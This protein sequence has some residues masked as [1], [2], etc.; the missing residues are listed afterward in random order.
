MRQS[1]RLASRSLPRC[2]RWR[3]GRP[4]RVVRLPVAAIPRARTLRQTAGIWKAIIDS[5][6]DEIL[7]AALLGPE[8]GEVITT[9]QVA[10]AAGL[11]YTVLRDAVITHPTMGEAC[12]PPV[13][14]LAAG[15]VRLA[16]RRSAERPFRGGPGVQSLI[17]RPTGPPAHRPHRPLRRS[18]GVAVFSFPRL[19]P[20][21]RLA[22]C[23][24][25]RGAVRADGTD[26]A[27]RGAQRRQPV[28]ALPRPDLRGCAATRRGCQRCGPGSTPIG[29][30]VCTSSGT[31]A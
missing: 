3:S 14:R 27:G 7:G 25:A 30:R 20:Q 18:I 23:G 21:A 19:W 31:V 5:S 29:R 4:I 22:K 2:R 28:G 13:A 15:D 12:R 9:V 16:H 24:G 26:P 1:A 10:M 8:A 11:P 17:H 6:S